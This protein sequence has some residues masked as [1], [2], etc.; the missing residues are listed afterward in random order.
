[1]THAAAPAGLQIGL[2]SKA[3][4]LLHRTVYVSAVFA[5]LHVLYYQLKYPSLHITGSYVYPLLFAGLLGL[6]AVWTAQAAFCK[7]KKA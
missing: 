4:K 5:A 1:M 2:G 7:K 6:R 3:W